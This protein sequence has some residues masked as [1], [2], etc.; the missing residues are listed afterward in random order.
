MVT[1]RQRAI[2]EILESNQLATVDE[3][4]TQLSVSE[5]TIRRD[6]M[7]LESK[8]LISRTWGGATPVSSVAFES[9]VYERT[10]ENLVLKQEIANAAVEMIEEGEVIALDVGTTC[11][12]VAKLLRRFQRITVFTN[13][14]LSAQILGNCTFNVHLIG[15]RMR[16]GEYSMVGSVARETALQFHYDK[17]FMGAS[18]F[19]LNHGPTD[20]NLDDVE[21]KQCFLKK[22]RQRIALLDHTKFGRVS[23]A[24]ICG[25]EGLTHIISDSE[26]APEHRLA[27]QDKGP[28]LV[29]GNKE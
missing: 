8:G 20:F 24:S 5:A 25:V 7:S 26:M 1:A 6:L 28:Q 2:I 29:V 9:F 21:I 11:M 14:M 19:D 23:L 15:G 3:L 12:E 4:S 22:A 13:S 16:P 10:K 27:L 17:Y 18:G